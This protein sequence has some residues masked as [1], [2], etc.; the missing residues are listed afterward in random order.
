MVVLSRISGYSSSAQQ[1]LTNKLQENI[2][3]PTKTDSVHILTAKISEAPGKKPR[4]VIYEKAIPIFTDLMRPLLA[5]LYY[6]V[7]KSK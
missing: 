1:V 7:P 2:R 4:D 6:F 3:K 5:V